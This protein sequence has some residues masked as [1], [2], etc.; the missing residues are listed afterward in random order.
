MR[1]GKLF[2]TLGSVLVALLPQWLFADIN[3]RKHDDE[4]MGP[5][6][7]HSLAFSPDGQ[8]FVMAYEDKTIKLWDFS[9]GKRIRVFRG[10]TGAV[11]SVAFS[12]DGHHILS[13]SMDHQLK[14]W[15]TSSGKQIQTFKGHTDAVVSVAFSSDGRL[16][17]S[18]SEDRDMKLWDIDTGSEI[19]SFR[20][21]EGYNGS[22]VAFS[23]DG[24]HVLMGKT[25]W[26]RSTGEAIRTFKST[27][28]DGYWKD[29][30]NFSPDGQYVWIGETLLDVV[31]GKAVLVL[32]GLHG[33]TLHSIFAHSPDGCF[34]VSGGGSGNYGVTDFWD[35]SAYRAPDQLLE[36]TGRLMPQS[37]MAS[38]RS[39]VTAIAI[40]PD[41][42]FILVRTLYRA[43]RDTDTLTLWDVADLDEP[44]RSFRA[45]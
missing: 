6:Y 22:A 25:L 39:P 12:P 10:H 24:Q 4:L 44:V 13:G 42:R 17:L 31:T 40:S 35:V 1:V 9:S 21:D 2:Y 29:S 36:Y 33:S 38:E 11:V 37:S 7:S 3:S 27:G 26:D 8:Y 20:A 5:Q 41:S 32:T 34:V 45:R 14:L 28:S 18:G 15:N 23:P 16:A 19:R 43:G 30:V